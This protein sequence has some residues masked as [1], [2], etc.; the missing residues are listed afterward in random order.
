MMLRFSLN[1]PK[2]A[3]RIEAAVQDGAGPGPAHAGHLVEGTT[4]V[5]TR[6]MGDAV[7]KALQRHRSIDASTKH[8]ARSAQRL[9]AF[10]DRPSPSHHQDDDH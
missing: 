3:E 7:V 4:Q 2:A 8:A 10:V 9:P 6:E 5:S 1:Q